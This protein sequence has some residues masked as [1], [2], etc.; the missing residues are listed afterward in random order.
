MRLRKVTDSHFGQ[1]LRIAYWLAVL[2]IIYAGQGFI[3]DPELD[4]LA[5]AGVMIIA[6]PLYI[7]G[8]QK[9]KGQ[10]VDDEHIE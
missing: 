7:W 1:V 2:V 3:S 9:I 6:F 4:W 10:Q 5:T 8:I